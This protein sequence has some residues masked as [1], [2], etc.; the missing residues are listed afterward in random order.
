MDNGLIQF[1]ESRK[2]S[3]V[4]I[5][6]NPQF[7]QIRTAGTADSPLFC[8]IDV[9]RALGYSNPAKAVIDHCKGVTI[10]ETPTNGGNNDSEQ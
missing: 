5:F 7:G 10:L 3:E 6:N 4:Q 1:G 2:V 9:A 8:A